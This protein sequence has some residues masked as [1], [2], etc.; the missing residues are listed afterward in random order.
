M[1]KAKEK[2]DKVN[3]EFEQLADAELAIGKDGGG[4]GVKNKK[5]KK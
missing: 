1:K 2:L 4:G 3:A 5:N